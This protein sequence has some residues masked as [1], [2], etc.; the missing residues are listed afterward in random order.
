MTEDELTICYNA[1][2]NRISKAEKQRDKDCASVLR[3]QGQ[4][5]VLAE[6]L[7]DQALEAVKLPAVDKNH[8]ISGIEWDSIPHNL[9]ETA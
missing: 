3:L 7:R 6:L 9:N 4:V 2:E 5:L 1:L 8:Q